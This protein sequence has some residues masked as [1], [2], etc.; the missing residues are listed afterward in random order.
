MCKHRYKTKRVTNAIYNSWMHWKTILCHISLVNFHSTMHIHNI[1]HIFSNRIQIL[2]FWRK[3]LSFLSHKFSKWFILFFNLFE[4][5]ISCFDSN[6]VFS[7][8]HVYQVVN[9]KFTVELDTFYPSDQ[10]IMIFKLENRTFL[11]SPDRLRK[12]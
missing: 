12:M 2:Y 4:N 8:P 10:V 6:A 11:W 9:L 5:A 1:F 3:K 7:K